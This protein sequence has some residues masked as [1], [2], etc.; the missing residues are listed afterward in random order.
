[1]IE[2]VNKDVLS[3]LFKGELPQETQQQIQEAREV[4]SKEKLKRTKRRDSQYGR[5]C[6]SSLVLPEILKDSR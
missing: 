4:R 3:F 5:T 2:K 6:C 1:M